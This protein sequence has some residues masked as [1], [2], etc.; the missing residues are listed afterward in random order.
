MANTRYVVLITI[1]I[2]FGTIFIGIPEY[3]M[4]S[5]ILEWES[6]N[7]TEYG[8]LDLSFKFHNAGNSPV[9]LS[10]LNLVVFFVSPS[11]DRFLIAG[12][13]RV[14]DIVILGNGVSRDYEIT[15]YNFNFEE[16]RSYLENK[17]IDANTQSGVDY[18]RECEWCLEVRASGRC[19]FWGHQIKYRDS[20]SYYDMT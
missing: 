5:V 20:M 18:L 7:L 6:V 12:D 4:R 1:I 11:G 2:V 8:R 19:Q 14:R 9:I 16:A 13:A 15:L 17:G 3:N 10:D